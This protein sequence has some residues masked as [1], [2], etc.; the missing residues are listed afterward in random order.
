MSFNL[1]RLQAVESEALAYSEGFPGAARLYA[2]ID[3]LQ[4]ALGVSVAAAH[5][6]EIDRD[7]YLAAL[8]AIYDGVNEGTLTT[9][10]CGQIA[11]RVIP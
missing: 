8:Q 3:D 7:L 2:R 5:D 11:G 4:R 6:A 9:G 1:E 10:G